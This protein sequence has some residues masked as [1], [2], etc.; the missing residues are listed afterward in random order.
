MVK[1]TRQ[2][3]LSGEINTMKLDL[4]ID[5]MQR[6]VEGKEPIQNIAPHLSR[7]EREFL[8]SGITPDEWNKTFG[9]S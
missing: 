7:D 3:I 4:T 2:S 6:Y 9:E 5:E 1:V 8:I